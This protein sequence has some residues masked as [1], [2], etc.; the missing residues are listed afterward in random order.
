MDL[1]I[2]HIIESFHDCGF[3]D[4]GGALPYMRKLFA[5]NLP[6]QTT[7]PDDIK[8]I[9]IEELKALQKA[10]PEHF[11]G[12]FMTLPGRDGSD[13][14]HGHWMVLHWILSKWFLKAKGS[15]DVPIWYMEIVQIVPKDI[16]RGNK[17][18]SD[19]VEQIRI[20]LDN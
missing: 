11:H 5:N 2:E 4:L 12:E 17:M 1:S 3:A 13:S 16:N 15:N 6:D 14:K 8:K 20:K 7:S 18:C 9:I 10:I 19:V